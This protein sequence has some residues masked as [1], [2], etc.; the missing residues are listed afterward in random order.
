MKVKKFSPF[1]F[2]FSRAD[3]SNAAQVCDATKMP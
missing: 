1:T 2:I 3:V